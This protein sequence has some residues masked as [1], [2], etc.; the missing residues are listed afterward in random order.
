MLRWVGHGAVYVL[1]GGL[2]GWGATTGLPLDQEIPRVR[3]ERYVV[4]Q[5]RSDWVVSADQVPSELAYGAKLV[6]ARAPER[7]QG[8]TEPIDPVAGHVPGAVNWP[9]SDALQP[10]GRMRPVDEL[11]ARLKDLTEPPGGLIAM[12]G[13]GVTA[14]HLLLAVTAAGLGDGRVYVGSWSEWIRDPQRPIATGAAS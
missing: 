9:F 3:A 7:Y 5:A 11:H 12:C 4:E 14:C 2:G 1:D 8:V 13:S 6:D 10:D